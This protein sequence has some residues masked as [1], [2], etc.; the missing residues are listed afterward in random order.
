MQILIMS[1]SMVSHVMFVGRFLRPKRHRL[2]PVRGLDGRVTDHGA[3][4]VSTPCPHTTSAPMKTPVQQPPIE[5]ASL[6]GE[7]KISDH[8][9]SLQHELH[10]RLF[11]LL[12]RYPMVD[13]VGWSSLLV[14]SSRMASFP[15]LNYTQ[16]SCS[17]PGRSTSED[18]TRGVFCKPGS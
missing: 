6:S 5:L 13:M 10:Q 4:T 8:S 14:V 3:L 18:S 1:R 15:T 16:S 7:H 12:T 11:Y 17:I 9:S 2:R